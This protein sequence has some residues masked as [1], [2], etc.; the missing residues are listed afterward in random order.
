MC[1]FRSL[2]ASGFQ[3]PRPLVTTF[4]EVTNSN[5]KLLNLVQIIR[6]K[7]LRIE[8]WD[9]LAISSQSGIGAKIGGDLLCLILKNQSSSGLEGMVVSKRQI[10]SLVEADIRPILSNTRP[11]QH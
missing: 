1:S 7:I 5:I 4:E 6:R 10:N 9:E 8:D 2:I 3:A 11:H